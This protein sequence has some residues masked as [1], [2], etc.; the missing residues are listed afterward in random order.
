MEEKL[1]K[2]KSELSVEL[3][4]ILDYWIKNTIDEVNGG[5]VGRID[6]LGNAHNDA[7]KGAVLNARILWT[8]SAAYNLTREP[9]YLNLAAR[10][11]QYI[12][13]YII[14]KEYGGVYWSVDHK[15]KPLETE[16]EIYALSFA[17][18]G[19]S[20]YV[21]ASGSEEAKKLAIDVY[22]AILDH[23]YDKKN[24]GYNE[25]F[26]RDWKV[27]PEQRLGP[28]N[29][30]VKKTMNTHLHLLEAFSALLG[31]W[32]DKELFEKVKE[33][34]S[35]FQNHIIS[36]K[37]H[38]LI[39]FFD[40]EWKEKSNIISYGHDIEAAWLLLE[41]AEKLKDEALIKKIKSSSIQITNAAAKGLDADG[42]L[43]NEYD[44]DKQHL[45]RQ[46]DWWPQAETMVGFFNAWQIS[47]EA[48]Y[49]NQSMKTWEFVKSYLLD[50]KI[51]EWYVGV[52]DEHQPIP[53]AD[54]VGI[55]KCPYHNGRACIEIIHRINL[56]S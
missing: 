50:K 30:G 7:P 34:V 13:D 5:F 24:G 45:Q 52:N 8:F 22:K 25:G 2:Y 31:V 54:K 9:V 28:G 23:S 10:A 17:V 4:N 46:K 18:Y 51:G 15:G 43:W 27:I 1:K 32:N 44:V 47:K 33:L 53:K 20:E 19:L 21:K 14:D 11:F 29:A 26:A 49:L 36:G 56:I 6:S 12:R 55:W 37:T 39:L 3:K 41:A 42:G 48:K 40:E 16:K 38:H 35:I